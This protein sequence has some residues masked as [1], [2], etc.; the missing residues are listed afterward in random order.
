MRRRRSLDSRR[1]SRK[2]CIALAGEMK[3][4]DWVW[5]GR[6]T[7]PA[8]ARMVLQPAAILYS[9]AVAAR[10]SLY[11]RG[12]IRTEPAAVPALSIGNLTVGG[13]GKTPIA[14]WAA[15]RLRMRGARPGVVLRGYGDDE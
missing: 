15:H 5:Y 9:A 2:R 7:M 3:A 8:I 1:C 10:G 6:G 12:L 14:A 13:T 4:A 11:D